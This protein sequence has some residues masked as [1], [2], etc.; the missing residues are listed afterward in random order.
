MAA[1][2]KI[3]LI[4]NLTRDPQLKQ[5]P[6]NSSVV[7]F[8]LAMSRKYKTASGE[9]REETCFVDCAAFGKQAEVIAQYCQ[10]GKQLFVEG[11]LKYDS[12]EDKQGFG[13]RSKVSVVVENFQFLG[14]R[15]DARKAA[16]P[17]GDSGRSAPPAPGNEPRESARSGSHAKGSE[18][19]GRKQSAEQPFGEE[20]MFQEA[21]IPF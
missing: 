18:Q 13:R 10:K 11:R 8:G 21:D 15:D 19:R 2:N 12:W 1:L 4:G 17:F 9:D 6:S 14:G 3:M 16:D 20:T 5:L 7:E